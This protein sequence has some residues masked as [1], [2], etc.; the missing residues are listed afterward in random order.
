MEIQLDIISIEGSIYTLFAIDIGNS[1]IKFLSKGAFLH[2]S[3]KS[4]WEEEIDKLLSRLSNQNVIF[5]ISSVNPEKEIYLIDKIQQNSLFKY[6]LIS[7]LLKEQKLV[8]KSEI[9]GIGHD[10][11]L[12]MIGGLNYA[13]PPFITIDMGTA[14]TINFLDKGRIVRGGAI[15][16]GVLTQ[17]RSLIENTSALKKIRLEQPKNLLGKNTNEAI[18]SGI[19]GGMNGTIIYFVNTIREKY[20]DKIPIFLTG[21]NSGWVLDEICS[22]VTDV[23]HI[24]TLVLQGIILTAK[25]LI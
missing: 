21:G 20:G 14:T 10:R 8:D 9:E 3:Y 6:I 5:F 12:G 11:L 24:P 7:A 15:L 2:F 16:P 22:K 17:F 18:S 23:N 19:I 13:E 1:A 25:T 4:N